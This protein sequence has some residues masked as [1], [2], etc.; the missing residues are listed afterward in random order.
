MKLL[1]DIESLSAYCLKQSK[2]NEANQLVKMYSSRAASSFEFR[3]IVFRSIYQETQTKLI[4]LSTSYDMEHQD[5]RGFV[6]LNMQSL[7]LAKLCES[8]LSFE[9]DNELMQAMFLSDLLVC[10][11]AN[12][13]LSWELANY[14]R[15]KL[16]VHLR[17]ERESEQRKQEQS[18]HEQPNADLNRF[19]LE[20]SRKLLDFYELTQSV[21]SRYEHTESLLLNDFMFKYDGIDFNLTSS[22]GDDGLSTNEHKSNRIERACE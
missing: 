22:Q 17:K 11:R 18:E 5:E 9:R 1:A 13:N 16:N 8:L 7:N 3:Q 19:E 6:K 12:L 21:C 10:T 4:E 15:I 2:L 14:A 20:L